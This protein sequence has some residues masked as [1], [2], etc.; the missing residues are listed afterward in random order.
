MN[1]DKMDI[2]A[3]ERQLMSMDFATPPISALWRPTPTHAHS[4]VRAALLAAAV[5]LLAAGLALAAGQFPSFMGG[6]GCEPPTCSGDFGV[7][8]R[9]A[10]GPD[11]LFGYDV[12][13][14]AGL[15]SERLTAIAAGLASEH[16][17]ERVI[18]WFFSE[19]AGQERFAFPLTPSARQA[20]PPPASTAAW[21][22]TFDYVRTSS[23]PLVQTGPGG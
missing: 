7:T 11:S 20:A 10:D 19:D 6:L 18:V 2:D 13:V 21:I 12:V 15:T 1:D 4:I 8:A 3:L 23:E 9:I 22:A 14:S 5:L 16:P 17:G